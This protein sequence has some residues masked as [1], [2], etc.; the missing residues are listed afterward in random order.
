MP[1]ATHPTSPETVNALAARGIDFKGRSQRL[2]P[3]LIEHADVIY[4]MTQEHLEAAQSML[5]AGDR[6]CVPIILAIDPQAE[7]EDPLGQ[8]QA[9]YD[10]IAEEFIR[11]IP[12]R[13]EQIR[14]P[15]LA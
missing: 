9:A 10:K 2:T 14:L 5:Q 12:T 3:E 8:G 6:D 4:G 13:L 11:L 15:D 7:I 1:R